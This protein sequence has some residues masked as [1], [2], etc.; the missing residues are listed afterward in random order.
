MPKMQA[1]ADGEVIAE[2]DG[3]SYERWASAAMMRRNIPECRLWE[4]SEQKDE[5]F[6]TGQ[7]VWNRNYDPRDEPI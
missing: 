2:G 5:W 1:R 7:S 6:D 4:W 3:G